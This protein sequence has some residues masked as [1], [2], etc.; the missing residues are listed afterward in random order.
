MIIQQLL[1]HQPQ[2]IQLWILKFAMLIFKMKIQF[3]M[4]QLQMPDQIP[5]II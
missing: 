4:Q 1:L 3:L 2:Q 5:N